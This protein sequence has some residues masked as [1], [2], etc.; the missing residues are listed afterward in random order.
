MATIELELEKKCPG[1]W[2]YDVKEYMPCGNDQYPRIKCPTCKGE[3]KVPS[4]TGQ[5]LLDFIRKY[6]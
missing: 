4:D 3:G 1:Y 6:S 2:N 5:E